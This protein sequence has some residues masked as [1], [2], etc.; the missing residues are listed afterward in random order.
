VTLN[1]G[2]NQQGW[3]VHDRKVNII[4]KDIARSV[5]DPAPIDPAALPRCSPEKF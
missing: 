2:Y 4:V 1:A 3:Q 5:L